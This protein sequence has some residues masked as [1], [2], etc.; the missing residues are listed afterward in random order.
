MGTFVSIMFVLVGVYVFIAAGV[1]ERATVL[2]KVGV[3]V[4]ELA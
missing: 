4:G 1:L 2:V 3:T